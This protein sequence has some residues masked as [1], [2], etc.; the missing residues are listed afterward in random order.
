M[1]VSVYTPRQFT[2]YAQEYTVATFK[3]SEMAVP[4]LTLKGVALADVEFVGWSRTANAPMAVVTDE[5]GEPHALVFAGAGVD[6]NQ[7]FGEKLQRADLIGL[8]SMP[9]A[10]RL[11]RVAPFIAHADKRWTLIADRNY[12]EY[13]RER[14]DA[15]E[16]AAQRR[17]WTSQ[18]GWTSR[19][20]QTAD[21][22]YDAGA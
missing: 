8:E 11:T 22:S 6:R 18:R 2:G 19:P 7:P 13:Q 10:E 21:A 20:R 4:V 12:E 9:L 15:R 14:E 17:D 5:D 16:Q 1:G 3:I